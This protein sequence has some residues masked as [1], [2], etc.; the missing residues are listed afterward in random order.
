[1]SRSKFLFRA[2]GRFDPNVSIITNEIGP[3]DVQIG[4]S[5]QPHKVPKTKGV[6]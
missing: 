4:S 1:M 5:F 2:D 3:K 6:A